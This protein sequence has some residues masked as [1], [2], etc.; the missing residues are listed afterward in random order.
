[1]HIPGRGGRKI[2][3]PAA[4]ERLAVFL[5]IGLFLLAFRF[6]EQSVGFCP[7][8][9][10]PLVWEL[11]GGSA[12]VL[13]CRGQAVK[14][15]RGECSSESHTQHST[16]G[17]RGWKALHGPGRAKASRPR[18][19]AALANAIS[20][21]AE[22]LTAEIILRSLSLSHMYIHTHARFIGSLLSLR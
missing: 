7:L 16:T 2:L 22:V 17:R 19:S 9:P 8:L 18:L 11:M 12:P 14:C 15:H 6:T 4:G 21:P 1:M 3:L 10:P 5:G 13:L 20:C